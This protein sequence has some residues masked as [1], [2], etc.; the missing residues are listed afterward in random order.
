MVFAFRDRLEEGIVTKLHFE[1]CTI[2]S[3]R[4]ESRTTVP[5]RGC[6]KIGGRPSIC[7]TIP[8]VGTILTVTY[9]RGIVR[10]A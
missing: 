1:S 4:G 9:F 5:A 10:S 3:K 7:G 2:T 8:P 6:I